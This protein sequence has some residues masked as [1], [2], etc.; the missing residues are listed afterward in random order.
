MT[1][2]MMTVPIVEGKCEIVEEEAML[3]IQTITETTGITEM[4]D[5]QIIGED[6][7]LSDRILLKNGTKDAPIKIDLI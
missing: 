5:I 4:V 6:T 1:T 7:E 3:I 2:M